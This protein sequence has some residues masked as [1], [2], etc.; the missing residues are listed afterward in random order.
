MTSIYLGFSCS[1]GSSECREV[2]ATK[3]RLVGGNCCMHLHIFC[4]GL[5][6][7][8][9]SA[10]HFIRKSAGPS[11]SSPQKTPPAPHKTSKALCANMAK[12]ALGKMSTMCKKAN[13][14]GRGSPP[15]AKYQPVELR[16]V[17][18]GTLEQGIFFKE[19]LGYILGI[20]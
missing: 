2:D 4:I 13:I 19:F 7:K 20:I 8:R 15:V 14:T 12:M 18:Q 5:A 10:R 1:F 11:F 17:L 9:A 16:L 6:R 3:W